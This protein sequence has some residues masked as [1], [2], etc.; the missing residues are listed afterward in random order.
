MDDGSNTT[1]SVDVKYVV[2]GRRESDVDIAYLRDPAL[3]KL[4]RG[5]RRRRGVARMNAETLGAVVLEERKRKVFVPVHRRLFRECLVP[6]EGSSSP[7]KKG[8]NEGNKK[9]KCKA[10]ADIGGNDNGGKASKAAKRANNDKHKTE[11]L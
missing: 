7:K 1:W 5:G 6:I 11:I 4:E 2:S 10:L 8:G 9:R 3:M